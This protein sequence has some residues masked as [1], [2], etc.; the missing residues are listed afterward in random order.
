MS[1]IKRFLI[2][3]TLTVFIVPLSV[4]ALLVGN[5]WIYGGGPVGFLFADMFFT[6]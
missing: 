3:M 4:L 5:S 2:A 1:H 6:R